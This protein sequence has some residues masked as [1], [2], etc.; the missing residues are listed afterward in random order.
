M[1]NFSVLV[2]GVGPDVNV[3][4][5]AEYVDR[6]LA[7][8]GDAGLDR[9]YVADEN[10]QEFILAGYGSDGGGAGT[11]V[12]ELVRRQDWQATLFSALSIF[13]RPQSKQ[14]CSTCNGRGWVKP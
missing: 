7:E 4:D 8:L 3:G 1:E 12:V 9:V 10:V 13:P 2:A 11:R 6:N 14:T 5:F